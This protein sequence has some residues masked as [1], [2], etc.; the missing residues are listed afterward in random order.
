MK[1]PSSGV[2]SFRY[3]RRRREEVTSKDKNYDATNSSFS[4][5]SGIDLDTFLLHRIYLLTRGELRDDNIALM[6]AFD[7]LFWADIMG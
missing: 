3:T 7:H 1:S 4:F 2:I 6:E 5:R